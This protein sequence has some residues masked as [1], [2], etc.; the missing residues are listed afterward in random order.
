MN[1]N[2]LQEELERHIWILA[3]NMT[4]IE[5]IKNLVEPLKEIYS[6]NFRHSYSRF[7]PIIVAIYDSKEEYTLEY[8]SNNLGD[9]KKSVD[10]YCQA[11]IK[12]NKNFKLSILKLCDHLNLEIARYNEY[13]VNTQKIEDVKVGI[14]EAQISK[15]NILQ[16]LDS[17]NKKIETVQAE[18]ITVLSIFSAIILTFS[19][20]V[21]SF[22]GIFSNLKDAPFLKSSFFIL[23]SG[24]IMVNLLF[25][26]MYFVAKITNRNIYARCKTDNCTCDNICEGIKRVKMRLPYIYYFNKTVIIAMVLVAFLNL[27]TFAETKNYLNKAFNYIGNIKIKKPK[28][29]APNK[30]LTLYNQENQILL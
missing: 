5:D 23:L 25:A 29:N 14:K 9:L 8:L 20:G 2:I 19:F 28:C 3:S 30:Q 16:E 13:L 26:M 1:P 4:T 11:D 17:A 22:S 15:N 12:K 18:L 27:F 7:F 21:S 24:F 10:E 6:K